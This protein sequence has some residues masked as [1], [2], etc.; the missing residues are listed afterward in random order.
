MDIYDIAKKSG[1]S[2]ATVSRVINKSPKVSDKARKII[3]EI[4]EE[5]NYKPNR[6][7]RSLAKKSTQ[8]IGIMVPD[9]RGHFASQSAYELERRLDELGYTTLL[10]VTTN[11]YKK[12]LSYLDILV[13]SKVDAI[14]GVGSTYEEKRIYEKL[15]NMSVIIPMAL[16]NVKTSD[17]NEKIVNVYIDEIEAMDQAV[18][19]FKDNG[20]KRPLYVS[21]DTGFRSRSYIAKK[22]GFVE[23]LYKYYDGANFVEFKVKNS[24][25]DLDRLVKFLKENPE[26]DSIQFELDKLAVNAYK[27]LANS[28]IKIPEDI[29]IIGFDNIKATEFTNQAITSIDQRISDQVEIAVDNLLR[30]LNQ[31]EAETNISL[32]AKLIEKE[33]T[34]RES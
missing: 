19:I 18:K 27:R 21:M 34:F 8:M 12:K 20:Y 1:Y 32:E 14:I 9:I 30:I 29:G 3:E 23:A 6:V 16:L 26:F 10:C 28:R 22:S 5:S 15:K 11:S 13:E 17:E 31:E 33:T 24:E 7:A 4:I 25:E 2:T